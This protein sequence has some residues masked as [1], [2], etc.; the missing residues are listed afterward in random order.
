MPSDPRRR[1]RIKR[2]QHVA[3]TLTPHEREL[4]LERTFV[5]AEIEGRL[6]NARASGSDLIVELTLDDVDDL[7]GHVAA[8]AN[9][10]SEVRVR[11]VLEAVYDRLANPRLLEYA[12]AAAERE[13]G[14]DRVIER[15]FGLSSA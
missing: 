11:R 7:A 13:A 4:I 8:Q 5:D 3:F 9:H 10:C 14:A 12:P 2:G 1:K 15:I 6:R